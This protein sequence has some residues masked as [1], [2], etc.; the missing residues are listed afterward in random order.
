MTYPNAKSWH[1][2]PRKSVMLFGMSGLGKTHISKFLVQQGG[3][4][5]YSIDY[6]IGTSGMYQHIKDNLITEA[7]K[8]PYLAEMLK[9]DAI[10]LEP[11]VHDHDLSAV[12]SYLGKPGNPAAG[13][14]PFEEYRRRQDLFRRAEIKALQET[15]QFMT[16][17]QTLYHYPHFICDTGGSIC[18]W[19]N[20]E[21]DDDPL[22]TMLRESC[23]P[24]WIK[25]DEA[26]T[27]ALIERFDRAP[28]PMAYQP[29]FLERVWSEYL[30]EN[31]Q[32]EDEVNPD[33]FIRWTYAQALAHRQPRYAAMARYGITVTADD[34]HAV[35]TAEDFNDLIASKL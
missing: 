13:G 3:W 26:H 35:N 18:E 16:R 17:A 20:P 4:F 31:N 6:R 19:I 8:N 12:A 23:L 15:A 10:Y 28:K 24:V 1:A 21:I 32:Q 29:E 11:N 7:M 25:G 33:S 9:R 27:Q 30:K 14:L 34:I 5:H 2:A 22:M